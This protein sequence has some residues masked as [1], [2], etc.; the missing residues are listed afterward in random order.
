M[1]DNWLLEELHE[2]QKQESEMQKELNNLKDSLSSGKK[3]LVAAAYE[4]DK[5]R[6]SLCDQ[7][8]AELQAALKE[9]QNLETRLSK[10]SSQDLNK[11]FKSWLKQK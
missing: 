11:N 9:K 5:F 6:W 3:N 7:K 4:C 8:D 2:R 10:L 1:D